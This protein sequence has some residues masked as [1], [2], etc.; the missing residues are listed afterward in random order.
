MIPM[1]IYMASRFKTYKELNEI[2]DRLVKQGHK[3]VSTWHKVEA[4]PGYNATMPPPAK[5]PERDARSM[6]VAERDL[7]EILGADAILLYTHECDLTPGGMWVEMGFAMALN[8]RVF[9]YGPRTNVFCHRA[10]LVDFNEQGELTV[11][12]DMEHYYTVL[13]ERNKLLAEYYQTKKS[14]TPAAAL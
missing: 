5:G 6:F 7:E 1:K 12:E 11:V 3:I 2:A 14:L 4:T 13:T 10:Q 8:K 9:I